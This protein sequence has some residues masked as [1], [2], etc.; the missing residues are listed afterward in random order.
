MINDGLL[1]YDAPTLPKGT[2]A[3]VGFSEIIKQGDY[4]FVTNVKKVLPEANKS[5]EEAKGKIV[6]EYQQYLEQNWV[7]ELRKEFQVKINKDVFEKV[8]NKLAN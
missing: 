6:N 1:E 3:E 8:K 5:F 7:N 2:K 4:Y